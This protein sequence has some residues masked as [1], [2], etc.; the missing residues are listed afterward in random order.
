[1]LLTLWPSTSRLN[2]DSKFELTLQFK[3]AYCHYQNND[4]HK[5][6]EVLGTVTL[7]FLVLQ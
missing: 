6:L 5:A 7:V 1:M 3:V 2:L 4:L